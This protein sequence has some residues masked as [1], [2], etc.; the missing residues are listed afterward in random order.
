MYAVFQFVYVKIRLK[1]AVFS[2][3]IQDPVADDAIMER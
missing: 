1:Y 2:A 3:R